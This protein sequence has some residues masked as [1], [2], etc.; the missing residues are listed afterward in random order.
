MAITQSVNCYFQG[1]LDAGVSPGRYEKCS[2]QRFLS[3]GDGWGTLENPL[4]VECWFNG[5]TELS[6]DEVKLSLGIG[7]DPE[8]K[9][10]CRNIWD[11]KKTSIS[12]QYIILEESTHTVTGRDIEPKSAVGCAASSADSRTVHGI[13]SSCSCPDDINK[14]YASGSKRSQSIVNGRKNCLEQTCLNQGL[15]LFYFNKVI[16]LWSGH[17]V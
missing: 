13:E 4:Q 1:I 14:D 9:R 16:T 11:E 10:S 5:E 3:K 6:L 15:A 17:N 2:D 8:Q 12:S 7:E